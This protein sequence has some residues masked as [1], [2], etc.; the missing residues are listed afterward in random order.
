M[1]YKAK[2]VFVEAILWQGGLN[3]C[4][5]DF[6]GRN[7]NRADAV[8]ERG[9]NDT[10]NVVVWN[11]KEKQWLNLPVG[12]YLIRGIAGEL[13]PCDPEIFLQKYEAAP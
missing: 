12:H 4:L 6:C 7:W 3:D 9:P 1:R 13:Y 5:D 11:V 2:P 8:D 10:E